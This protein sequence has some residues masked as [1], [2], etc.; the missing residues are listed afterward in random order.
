LGTWGT[1]AFANDDALDWIAELEG[2]DDDRFLQEALQVV[3][4]D[5]G[6]YLEVPECNIAL[7]AAEVVAALH[8]HPSHDLPAVAPG[9]GLLDA[10]GAGSDSGG[11][12]LD[13]GG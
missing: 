12:L 7:A 3:I 9:G 6:A 1:E 8:G 2:A 10:G 4:Q 13:A 11:G 5:E